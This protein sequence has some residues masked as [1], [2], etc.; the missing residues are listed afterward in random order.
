MNL[1][2][3]N[4]ATGTVSFTSMVTTVSTNENSDGGS[5]FFNF[6]VTNNQGNT[7]NN[8]DTGDTDT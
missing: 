1:C 7:G 6:T 3:P 2:L 4:N 5:Q 8:Q